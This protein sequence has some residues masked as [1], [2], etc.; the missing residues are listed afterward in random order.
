MYTHKL[1]SRFLFF[2]SW[3]PTLRLGYISGT[4]VGENSEITWVTWCV[5]K[6][7]VIHSKKITVYKFICNFLSLA[8]LRGW[9]ALS[10]KN[11]T[12][13]GI[14]KHLGVLSQTQILFHCHWERREETFVNKYQWKEKCQE[15][16]KFKFYNSE[17][18]RRFQVANCHKRGV[19]GAVHKCY[20]RIRNFFLP[21][22]SNGMTFWMIDSSSNGLGSSLL[23]IPPA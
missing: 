11:K 2:R 9:L 1:W 22:S 4:L 13:Q 8:H 3:Q 20:V 23:I 17:R 10:R 7:W 15:E 12:F 5:R 16:T 19:W 14:I 21:P 6:L 18:R